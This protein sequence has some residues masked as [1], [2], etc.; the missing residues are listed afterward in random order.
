M[1]TGYSK[2]RN[3]IDTLNSLLYMVSHFT[4]KM[5]CNITIYLKYKAR[6]VNLTQLCK[7]V[8]LFTK[9]NMCTSFIFHSA[10]SG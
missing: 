7:K 6:Q 9:T 1:K 8:A 2:I 4:L 10:L 5:K 3:K